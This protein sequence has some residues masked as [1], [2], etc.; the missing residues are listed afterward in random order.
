MMR[1][2]KKEKPGNADGAPVLF[3]NENGAMRLS[4]VPAIMSSA[5]TG[6]TG[7]SELQERRSH[8]RRP[9]QRHNSR[10]TCGWWDRARLGAVIDI[11]TPAGRVAGDARPRRSR[12]RSRRWDRS[13]GNRHCMHFVSFHMNATEILPRP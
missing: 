3:F 7:R 10:R 6:M 13:T 4:L 8:S 5:A 9:R 12:R 1:C 2:F 11:I